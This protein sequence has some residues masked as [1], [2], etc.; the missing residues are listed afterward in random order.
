MEEIKKRLEV[1]YNFSVVLGNKVEH[2]TIYKAQLIHMRNQGLTTKEI[3]KI[4]ETNSTTVEN[5]YCKN[6]T[7]K[8]NIIA[9]LEKMFFESSF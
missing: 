3:G 8:D 7:P 6:S 9:K 5:W 1:I 4:L 2:M